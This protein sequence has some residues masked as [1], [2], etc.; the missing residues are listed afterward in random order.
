MRYM[1]LYGL[2]VNPSN[3]YKAIP[4]SWALD[5][6]SNAGDYVDQLTD[7]WSDSIAAEYFYVMHHLRVTRTL[8]ITLPFVSGGVTFVFHRYYDCKQRLEASGPYGFSLSWDNLSPR[9]L[10]IAGALGISRM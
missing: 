6:I 2:R 8:T 3:I 4:W 10:A 5:W 7:I 1:T 9:Q